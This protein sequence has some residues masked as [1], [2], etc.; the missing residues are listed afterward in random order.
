MQQPENFESVYKQ[1]EEVVRHLD[2][3]GLTLDES[4]ALYEQ[5]M[6]LAKHCQTLLDQAELRVI[7]LQDVFAASIG[8]DTEPDDDEDEAS[9]F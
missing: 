9:S 6:T 8:G 5:G 7:Q 4:I 3:G 1:L 2:E